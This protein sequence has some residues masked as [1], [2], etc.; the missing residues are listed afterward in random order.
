MNGRGLRWKSLFDPESVA[1]IG[2]SNTPGKIGM[3]LFS[4]IVAGGFKG[5][6]YPVNPN[7]ESVL[8]FKAYPSIRQ[9]PEDVELVVITVPAKQVVWSVRK[10]AEKGVD[11]CVVITAGFKEAG[12][13]GERMQE[14]LVRICDESGMGLVGPNCMGVYSASSNLHALMNPLFPRKGVVSIISQSGTIGM[15]L[16]DSLSQRGSGVA[17]FV[18]S[19]NEAQ[20]KLADYLEFFA[21]DPETKVVVAFV[22]GVRDGRK[23]MEA[24]RKVTREKPFICLKGGRTEAGTKAARSHTASIAGSLQVFK[25][26][27]RQTGIILASD[28]EE[29]TDLAVAFSLSPL[30]E[31]QKV[32]IVTGGGGWGVLTADACEEQGLEVAK[33]P[34]SVIEKISSRAPHYW[35]HGNPVDLVAS[36]NRELYA[37]CY[38]ILL[39]EGGVDVLI[40][41]NMAYDVSG[42]VKRIV[43]SE[44]SAEAFMDVLRRS[45]VEDVAGVMKKHC[46]PVLVVAREEKLLR[47]MAEAGVPA[48]TSPMRAAKCIARMV[49]YQTFKRGDGGAICLRGD[50]AGLEAGNGMVGVDVI[51]PE[52]AAEFFR[53]AYTAIDGVWF[54]S[55]EEK[56]GLDRAAELDARVW[57]VFAK[58]LAKRIMRDFNIKGDGLDTL[59]RTIA[60][61]WRMEGWRFEVPVCM[62]DEAVMVVRTCPWLEALRKAGREHVVPMMCGEI[63][64][65]VYRNWAETVN[66]KITLERTSRMGYGAPFCDF[67]YTIK[68]E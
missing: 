67:K 9:V 24:A 53:G 60:L 42:G 40:V 54:M 36:M 25:A 34:Q 20:V 29:L 38:D 68:K 2:A 66:P 32:G 11:W 33:L 61:R 47:M 45:I 26:A 21:H 28:C 23:F 12:G 22:E 13:E 3:I 41:E 65:V 50:G 8:G 52:K 62:N 4:T 37:W 17:R 58:I 59:V 49:E 48:F 16:M 44:E 63:C 64:D 57:S 30:P 27:A 14:E 39:E 15:M 31:G 5:N 10:C 18:S 6:V 19:G 1:V 43:G 7:A 56:Y 51:S 55:V 46:K 35:S